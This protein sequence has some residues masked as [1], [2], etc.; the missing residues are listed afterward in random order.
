MDV[1]VLEEL[2]QKYIQDSPEGMTAQLL[3]NI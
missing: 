2:R 3:R 1:N